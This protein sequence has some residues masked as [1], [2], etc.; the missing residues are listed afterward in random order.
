MDFAQLILAQCYSNS[1]QGL[2]DHSILAGAHVLELGSVILLSAW[3]PSWSQPTNVRA[4]TG[5]LG[6][7]LSPLVHRYTSTDM[8]PLIPLIQK[9]LSSNLPLGSNVVAKELDWITLAATL[10]SKRSNVFNTEEHPIDL[11]LAVDCLYH[12]SLIPPFLTTIDYLATP[13]RTTVLIVSELRAEDVTRTFLETWLSMSAWKIWRVP[14]DAV[15]KHYAIWLGWKS[16]NSVPV[17][18]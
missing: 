15:G 14:N 11:L 13:D 16:V 2:L 4:G 1:T 7:A 17:N 6:I 12:P 8:A 5:L 10:S 18:S 3:S 9:N